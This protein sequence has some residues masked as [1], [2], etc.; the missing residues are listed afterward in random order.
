MTSAYR[1]PMRS[2][3]DDVDPQL[4]LD[5]AFALGLCGFGDDR[6]TDR[7][8]RRVQ[9]FAAVPDGSFVWTRD[10]DGWYWLGR[11]GGRYFYDAGGEVVDLVHVRRCGWRPDPINES[12]CPAAVV[13]TFGRGGRNFQQIHDARVGEESLRLWDGNS[14]R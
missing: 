10:G 9:R 7:L 14:V 8:Q 12:R 11:L 3:R 13:A 6:D 2:R 4:A 5:R 1:A